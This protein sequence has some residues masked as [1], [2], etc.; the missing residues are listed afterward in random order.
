MK[1][2]GGGGCSGSSAENVKVVVRCRPMNEQ[3]TSDGNTRVVE[4]DVPRGVVE[5]RSAKALATDPPKAFTFDAVY[6]WNSKQE[7]L[8]DETFRPLIDSVLMGFNGTIFAYGQTGTGKTYTM[9]GLPDV[10][11]QRGVIPNSFHHIFSHIARSTNQQFLIRAS[12]LEIYQ[13]EIRDLLVKE[14]KKKHLELKER[15]DTGVYV[16]DLQQ[17]VCKS[18]TEIQHVMHVGN[19]NRAVGWV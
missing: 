11:E 1:K 7:E 4:M 12:Y 13:E 6:D 16:K 18:I 14:H 9:E 5:V 8:Y 2:G 10:P 3:E 17:F 19:Q 15:P